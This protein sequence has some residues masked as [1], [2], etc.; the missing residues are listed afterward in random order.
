MKDLTRPVEADLNSQRKGAAALATT[1]STFC[2]LYVFC[3]LKTTC[4]YL[5]WLVCLLS[6]SYSSVGRK[7]CLQV[8]GSGGCYSARHC[9]LMHACAHT[10][11]VVN[12]VPT[13]VLDVTW[14]L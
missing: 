11:A 7:V 13:T 14:F 9:L 2:P 12:N 3:S 4:F 1:L 5:G 8:G 6:S 10:S